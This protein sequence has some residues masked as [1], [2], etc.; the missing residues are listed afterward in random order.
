M[1]KRAVLIGVN[2]Y[3]MPGADLRGCVSDVDTMTTL[4]TGTFGFAAGDVMRLTD[5]AATKKAIESAIRSLVRGGRRGDVLLI[6][7]SGH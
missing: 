4:L 2:R 7:F 5:F 6:H 1:A 3:R